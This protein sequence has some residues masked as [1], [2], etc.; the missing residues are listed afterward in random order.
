MSG[1]EASL[2]ICLYKLWPPKTSPSSWQMSF[3]SAGGL[4]GKELQ[5]ED[6][7]TLPLVKQ[8]LQQP[9]VSI[10]GSNPQQK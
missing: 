8:V 9:N 10:P 1:L 7:L 4:E 6:F 3:I 5:T 2:L